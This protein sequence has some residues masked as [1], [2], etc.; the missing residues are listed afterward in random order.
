M[1][2]SL[3]DDFF[4]LGSLF[5]EILTGSLLY[6]DHTNLE[7][8]EIYKAHGLPPLDRMRPQGFAEVMEILE[9]GIHIN[10]GSIE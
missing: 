2:S 5:Y 1:E 10:F 6:R 8:L 9:C 7:V 3:M 4:S